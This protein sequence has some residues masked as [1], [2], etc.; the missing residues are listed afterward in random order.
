MKTII[1]LLATFIISNSALAQVPQKLSYQAVIRNSSNALVTNSPVGTKISVLQGSVS[2]S[3]VYSETHTS[4]TNANGLLSIEIGTGSIVSGNFSTINWSSGL[5]FLKTET[6]PSGGSSYTIIGTSQLLSV[7]YALHAKTA[8][9]LTNPITETQDLTNVLSQGNNAGANSIVNVSKLAIGSTT[10]S[11]GTALDI[12]STTGAL[13]LPRMTTSQRNALTPIEGMMIYN[14]DLGKFQGVAPVGGI[15]TL[16]Q[17]VT[18]TVSSGSSVSSAFT[19]GGQSFTAGITGL[20]S[21]VEFNIYQVTTPGTFVLKIYSGAGISGTLL[22]SKNVTITTATDYLVTLDNPPLITNGQTYSWVLT[23]NGSG[24]VFI[25]Y[26]GGTLN[27]PGGGHITP[28][29]GVTPCC[30]GLFKTYII[31]TGAGWVDFH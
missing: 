5:Y 25:S 7:P 11:A 24:A 27:Y 4:N 26:D 6:D 14:T 17:S 30:D 18:G 23:Y 9:N 16:D 15:E 10:A 20:L 28:G 22:D 2:G 31:P 1:I 19:E 12:T 3:V 21:K 8:D 13:L 29:G